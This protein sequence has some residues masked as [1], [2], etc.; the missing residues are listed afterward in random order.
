VRQDLPG[1]PEPP[2]IP[3][4]RPPDDAD[5][6]RPRRRS[7]APSGVSPWV[8]AGVAAAV[9]LPLLLVGCAVGLFA[10]LGVAAYSTSSK[11]PSPAVASGPK[12]TTDKEITEQKWEVDPGAPGAGA[13]VPLPPIDIPAPPP[14]DIQP[15]AL[16]KD[17]VTLPLP[18]KVGDAAVGGGGRYLVLLLPEQGKLAVF[19]VNEAKVVQSLPAAADVK[20][21]AGMDKFVVVR[22]AND[23]HETAVERWSFATFQKEAEGKL[24]L[25]VPLV[26]AAMGSASNG[27]LVVSGVDWPRLGE[28]AFFDVLGMKRIQAPFH[29]H[30]TFDTSPEVFLRASADGHLFTCEPQPGAGVESCVWAPAG[31]LRCAGGAGDRPVPGPDGRVIYTAQGRLTPNL[32]ALDRGPPGRLVPAVHGPYVLSLVAPPDG[33]NPDVSVYRDDGGPPVKA[34]GGVEGAAEN[35]QGE[36]PVALPLD[37]RLFLI[38]EAKLLVVIPPSLDRLI[39]RRCDLE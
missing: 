8:W 32:D 2:P 25:E 9:V 26:A 3:R 39:V 29:P 4:R 37:R 27:P 24:D 16:D 6:Y 11:P 21:A 35:V 36:P 19:D 34:L 20:I 30:A 33:A 38:P 1:R 7:P 17:V 13:G 12:A 15:P 22:P 31:L 28:T 23:P 5:A 18:G 14:A 10:V